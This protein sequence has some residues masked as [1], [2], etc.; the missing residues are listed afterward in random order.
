MNRVILAALGVGLLA[1]CATT[2]RVVLHG[3]FADAQ[4]RRDNERLYQA[5]VKACGRGPGAEWCHVAA[6]DGNLSRVFVGPGRDVRPTAGAIVYDESQ[7][8]GKYE[9]GL[10]KGRPIVRAET[11]VC[12]GEVIDGVCAGPQF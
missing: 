9:H 2:D 6:D 4:N 8:A 1:G 3:A 12:H 5:D 11:P 7:C 10:C